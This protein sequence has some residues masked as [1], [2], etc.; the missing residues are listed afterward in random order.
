MLKS[1]TK[2]FY[3]VALA[4]LFVCAQSNRFEMA[5]F[6]ADN[7]P[8][9]QSVQFFKDKVRPIL[10]QNCYPCHTD[11]AMG[12]L[13]VDS[14][15]GLLTGGGRGPAIVPGDPDKSLLIEAVR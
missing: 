15:E 13:R 12:R 2:S 6:G 1:T 14:R 11:A 5:V 10:T 7:P 4:A 3:L 8:T 9:T